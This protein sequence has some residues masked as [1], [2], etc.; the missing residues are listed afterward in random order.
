MRS[1]RPQGASASAGG[2][3]RKE[4][5]T[6]GSGLH[7]RNT[8]PPAGSSLWPERQEK[9]AHHTQLSPHLCARRGPGKAA[10][11]L[12]QSRALRQRRHR[13]GAGTEGHHCPQGQ[14]GGPCDSVRGSSSCDSGAL[15]Q[16]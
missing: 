12:L 8:H 11:A 13:R 4:S 2:A 6:L 16:R 7:R 3:R 9:K 5:A 14:P 10:G 15:G 1:G